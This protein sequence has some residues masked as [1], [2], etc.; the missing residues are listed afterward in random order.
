MTGAPPLISVSDAGNNQRLAQSAV[1]P[2]ATDGWQRMNF[3]FSTASLTEAIV[4]RIQRS[5][6]PS[7]P[8]PIFGTMWLDDFFIEDAGPTNSQR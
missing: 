8:C 3:E 2:A 6:C 1:F 4:L 5:D 7:A